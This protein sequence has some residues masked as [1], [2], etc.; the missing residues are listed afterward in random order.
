M[1]GT[2][3][4]VSSVEWIIFLKEKRNGKYADGP[5]VF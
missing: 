4:R 2:G 5:D 3:I 1:Y